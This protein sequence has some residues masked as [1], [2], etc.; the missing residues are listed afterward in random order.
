MY[1]QT[2]QFDQIHSKILITVLRS[3]MLEKTS[4]H[5]YGFYFNY[6]IDKSA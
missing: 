1:F 4:T 3:Q 6:F 2:S 5:G